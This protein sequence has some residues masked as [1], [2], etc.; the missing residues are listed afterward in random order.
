M[1]VDISAGDQG[2]TDGVLIPQFCVN[3]LHHYSPH[4]AQWA[5]FPLMSRLFVYFLNDMLQFS[6]QSILTCVL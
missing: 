5:L 6:P 2:Y 4:L 3:Y 1:I